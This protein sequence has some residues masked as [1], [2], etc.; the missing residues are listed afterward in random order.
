[1][2]NKILVLLLLT[3]G[4]AYAQ[5]PLDHYTTSTNTFKEIANSTHQ[6][7]NPQDLDFVP[8]RQNEWWV[9]NKEANGGSTVLIFDAGLPT[10]SSQ[11]RRD[12]HNEHFMARAVAIAFGANKVMRMKTNTGT[13]GATLPVPPS[14][15]EPLAE[16]KAVTGATKEDVVTSGLTSPSGIDYRKD[17]IVVSDYATGNLYIYNVTTS[18]ATL[19]GTI[20]TGGPGVMGVRID[21][22]N[23][24][25]YVNAT[26][27][28]VMRIENPNVLAIDEITPALS[29][30]VY[31]NP[32]SGEVTINLNDLKTGSNAE[33]RV[34]DM[35]GRAVYNTATAGSRTTIN[36]S[37]WAKG[38][39]SV[40]LIY[41]GSS[42]STRLVVQ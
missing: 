14:G 40:A 32:T 35:T 1:M 18:P 24:I 3:G 21:Y 17:R 23:R 27:N 36:T 41:N 19:V 26:T 10:Q 6:V 37:N 31:P 13:V 11:F 12:S 29:Y 16:Y 28:K 15:G 9:L 34:Y 7:N 22:N 33:I 30:E 4:G 2:K 25:W 38:M 42:T 5:S 20:V 8:G 39:Y